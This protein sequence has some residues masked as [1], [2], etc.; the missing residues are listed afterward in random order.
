MENEI[1]GCKT[2]LFVGQYDMA[3][4]VSKIE[5]NYQVDSQGST[6]A[7]CQNFIAPDACGVVEGAISPKATCD[8]Y[9]ADEATLTDSIFAGGQ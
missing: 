4:L 7:T 5:S 1:W 8:F 2:Q 3:E 9:L 6:C